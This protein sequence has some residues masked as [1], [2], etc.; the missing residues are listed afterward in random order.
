MIKIYFITLS[1]LASYLA[2]ARVYD[3]NDDF[4]HE[5][6]DAGYKRYAGLHVVYRMSPFDKFSW[7]AIT[8]CLRSFLC[9]KPAPTFSRLALG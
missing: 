9:E 8:I 6:R 4:I 5:A 1:L 2:K 3:V 7:H